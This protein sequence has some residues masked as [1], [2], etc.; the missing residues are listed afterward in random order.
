MLAEEGDQYQDLFKSICGV[1]FFGTPHREHGIQY[2][3]GACLRKI[4]KT[5]SV[6]EQSRELL[7][8][9]MGDNERLLKM[10]NHSFKTKVCIPRGN[11]RVVSFYETK[12]MPGLGV[13]CSHY[14]V[15]RSIA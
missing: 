6:S 4:A 9:N 3:M 8:E 13:V 7:R 15:Y 14:F 12:P 11:L 5:A 10:V 1:T 2:T